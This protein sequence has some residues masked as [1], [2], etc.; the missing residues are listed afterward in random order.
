MKLPSHTPTVSIG[1]GIIGCRVA[2]HLYK[3]GLL[4]RAVNRTR[5]SR[6]CGAS[7]TK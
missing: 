1:G 7:E 2:Y 3:F 4:L 6:R 5:P